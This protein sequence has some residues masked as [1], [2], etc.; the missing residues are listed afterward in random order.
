MKATE[1]IEKLSELIKEHGDCEV[2]YFDR[3]EMTGFDEAYLIE[4]RKYGFGNE[5]KIF[6]IE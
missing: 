1:M 6:Y 4:Q 5:T 2:Y 3:E